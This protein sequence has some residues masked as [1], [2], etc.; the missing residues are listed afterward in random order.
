MDKIGTIA[1]HVSDC[2]IVLGAINGFDPHDA[3]SVLQ[4]YHWSMRQDARGL[5]VAYVPEWFAGDAAAGYQPVL[6]ALRE[7]G[8]ILV[9]VQPPQVDSS[10]LMLP[11]A[12]EAAAAFEELTRGNADDTL[13]WQADE[14]WP[15][16]FRQA[17]FIP[18]IE[19]LQASRLRRRAM[20]AM[21]TWFM[22]FDAVVAPPFAGDLLLLT[23]SCGQPCVVA[24]CGFENP[25]TPR[26][27][28]VMA[29]NFD[30]G[31]ALRVASAIEARLGKW[32]RF[33]AL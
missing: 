6:D 26:S 4:P 2:G 17:W 7:A 19:M 25:Q 24:R 13:T 27:V 23:N 1:R 21:H 22:Q 11:I 8:A 18:A 28:T 16:T 30:E 33:P 32:D 5:R 20:E 15:N 31:T 9:E 3:S 10:A 12:V 29:R 14:A